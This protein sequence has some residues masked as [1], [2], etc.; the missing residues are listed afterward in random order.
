M[1]WKC[2][3]CGKVLTEMRQL[4]I[5]CSRECRFRDVE[6]VGFFAEDDGTAIV[7][8][9]KSTTV[10]KVKGYGKST[11]R[12]IAAGSPLRSSEE[13]DQIF[14][15]CKSCEHFKENQCTTCGCNVRSS[16]K[17]STTILGIHV[18]AGMTNKLRRATEKC[19]VGKW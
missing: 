10:Q 15:I 5:S 11:L 14:S 1:K 18:P 9:V 8:R 7:P 3:N 19:P 2:P 16:Q 12:W 13:V 6:G 4:P 17:E